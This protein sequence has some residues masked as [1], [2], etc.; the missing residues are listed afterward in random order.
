MPSFRLALAA[1]ASAS[2]L[3]LAAC[4]GGGGGGGRSPD[5]AP[6][7][8]AEEALTGALADLAAK[9]EREGDYVAAVAH[10]GRLRDR[11]PDAEAGRQAVL[12]QARNLR[13]AGRPQQ[14]VAALRRA[15]EEPQTD[16][17]TRPVDMPEASEGALRLELAKAYL[18]AG[19]VA[20]AEAQAQEAHGLAPRQAE[21][22]MVLALA[23]DR[24]GRW[25]DARSAYQRSLEL[26]PEDAQTLNN[27]ALSLAQS[28]DLPRAMAML[29]DLAA[30]PD[31]PLQARQ[32]LALLH[33]MAGDL[34]TA[35]RMTRALLPAEA[36]ERTI[37]D[38][39]RIAP[40]GGGDAG[41]T[42]DAE[43]AAGGTA[44]TSPAA[45]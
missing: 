33:A 26:R 27:Y 19:L 13:Y 37:A 8:G 20:D 5:A 28:G 22:L 39:R 6:T 3:L 12:G 18:A 7:A 34:E 17:G 40:V 43:D 23:Y 25:D 29:A 38:L 41:A 35:E 24:Q 31:A 16:G 9:A 30:R 4:A 36:A 11:A 21:A 15:L 14:A 44:I 1:A 2:V 45:P 10:Y 42:E 32:N